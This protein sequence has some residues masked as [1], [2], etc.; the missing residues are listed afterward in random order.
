MEFRAFKQL[1]SN[2]L[3]IKEPHIVQQIEGAEVYTE[4]I[5][6]ESRWVQVGTGKVLQVETVLKDEKGNQVPLAE[7]L[8][9]LDHYKSHTL[10]QKAQQIDKKKTRFFIVNPDGSI[11]DETIPYP[12]TERIEV[13]DTSEPSPDPSIA[14]AYWVPA[15]TIEPFLIHEEYELPG[16]DPRKDPQVFTELEKALKRDEIAIFTYSNGSWK[17]YYAFLVPM[18][19]DGKFVW[20]MK[21]S[22]KQVEYNFLRDVPA[23]AAALRQ[24]KTL[25]TLP[26]I[27]QVITIPVAKKK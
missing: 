6:S 2:K 21:I 16:A 22:D 20:L 25:T 10:D 13:K 3:N 5:I 14:Y 11:G 4:R 7:A 12:P 1:T 18:I 26:P 19:K 23:P 17:L 27:Q 24:V 9:I 8:N 15:T